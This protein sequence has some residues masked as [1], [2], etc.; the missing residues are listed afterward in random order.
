M[1]TPEENFYRVSH[2]VLDVIPQNLRNLFIILWNTKYPST[3]WDNRPAC[4]QVFLQNERNQTVR[5]TVHQNMFHGDSNKFD[6]TTLFS[7]LLYSSQNF[8]QSQPNVRSEIDKLRIIRNK[9]FAHL[10][11]ASF[12]DIEYRTLLADVKAMFAR[13]GWSTDPI[14]DIG[15][16]YLN[17]S[18]SKKLENAL[19]AEEK[20]NKSFETRLS[21]VETRMHALEED[22]NA[23]GEKIHSVE[24]KINLLQSGVASRS[25]RLDYLESEI[26][27]GAVKK[28][29][30]L[31]IS[32]CLYL[33]VAKFLHRAVTLQN[34]PLLMCQV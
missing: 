8:C 29:G 6:G 34:I 12:A 5:K 17:I 2:I 15:K 19:I 3:P 26:A 25:A 21:T 9:C 22:F 16:K 11:N 7:I 23:A 18:Q 31:I 14:C 1:E 28:E 30:K 32:F 27:T 13:L 20:R 4:G 33:F 24:T 10:P